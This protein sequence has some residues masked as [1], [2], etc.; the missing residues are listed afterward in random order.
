MTFQVQIH[1]I[2]S[3]ASKLR[4]GKEE[5]DVASLI[6]CWFWPL[7][8]IVWSQMCVYSRKFLNII[9]LN[10]QDGCGYLT[11]YFWIIKN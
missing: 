5:K 9:P 7:H 1:A 8:H 2:K 6:C 3:G 10:R 11:T 4:D